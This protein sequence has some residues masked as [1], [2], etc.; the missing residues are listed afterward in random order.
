MD[1]LLTAVDFARRWHMS[2]GTVRRWWREGK[3]PGTLHGKELMIPVEAAE[4]LIRASCKVYWPTETR[5]G[6]PT[7]REVQ[8]VLQAAERGEPPNEALRIAAQRWSATQPPVVA[9]GMVEPYTLQR[10]LWKEKR[11]NVRPGR[12][13]EVYGERFGTGD[14]RNTH[15]ILIRYLDNDRRFPRPRN[16]FVRNFRFLHPMAERVGHA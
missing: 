5:G 7:D 10:G 1:E 9:D 13:V 15:Y 12:E 4:L 3:I 8:A 14:D 2:Q 16:T 6:F 11:G